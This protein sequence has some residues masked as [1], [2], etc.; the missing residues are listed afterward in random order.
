MTKVHAEI[1]KNP[2][3]VKKAPKA[4][5]DRA[6]RKYRPQRI[7]LAQRKANVVEKFKIAE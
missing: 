7:T 4:N 3:L 6:H 2:D 1:R 5:P